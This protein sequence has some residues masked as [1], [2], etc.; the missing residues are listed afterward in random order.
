[1]GSA[2]CCKKPEEIL[3]DE[4]KNNGEGDKVNPLDQDSYPQD[5][6]YVLKANMNPEEEN[7]PNQKLYEQEGSPRISK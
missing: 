3:I 5:T 4:I 1:M 7:V 6:E 2:N